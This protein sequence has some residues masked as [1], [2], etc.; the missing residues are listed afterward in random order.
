MSEAENNK[1]DNNDKKGFST[2]LK[3]KDNVFVLFYAN[4]CG[5]SRRF[6]P[7]FEEFA[8]NNPNECLTVVVDDEPEL[9]KEYSIKYYPTLIMFKKGKLKKS[10]DSKPGIGL[11]KKQLTEFTKN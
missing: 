11:D 10:L 3:E 7:I 1:S 4:W 8:Q 2:E 6:L 5:F 9:C